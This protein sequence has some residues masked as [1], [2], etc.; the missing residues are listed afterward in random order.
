MKIKALMF[1]GLVSVPFMASAE[2]C[3]ELLKTNPTIVEVLECF[4]R[5]LDKLDSYEKRIAKLEKENQALRQKTDAISVSS[6]G[7]VG[8]GTTN[9]KQKLHVEVGNIMEAANTPT[10]K[11]VVFHVNRGGGDDPAW[12]RDTSGGIKLELSHQSDYGGTYEGTKGGYIQTVSEGS[13]SSSVTM[14]FG[15]NINN[16]SGISTKMVIKG[17]GNVGIGT[18][19]PSEKLE[20]NGNI[21]TGDIF[22]EKDG[23]TLWQLFED[24]NG[25][26]LKQLKTGKT[27]R[28]MLEEIQ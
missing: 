15:T 25:L 9:P 5:G 13:Y 24:E 26:Y 28:L 11:T 18:K 7:N 19:S 27:F 16:E 12:T 21:K 1:V 14:E 10:T 8:I 22:F 17:N 4:Q 23:E 3:V 2:N 20:V 6:D